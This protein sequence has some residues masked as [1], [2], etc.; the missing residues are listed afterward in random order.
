MSGIKREFD[1]SIDPHLKNYAVWKRE[2]VGY[3]V[4][5]QLKW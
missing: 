3:G 2:L 5:L 1:S 4:E